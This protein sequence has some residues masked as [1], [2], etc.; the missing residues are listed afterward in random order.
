VKSPLWWRGSVA[1]HAGQ[2]LELGLGADAIQYKV[3]ARRLLP[4]Y[5]GV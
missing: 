3:K 1:Y 2:L 4:V 5:N